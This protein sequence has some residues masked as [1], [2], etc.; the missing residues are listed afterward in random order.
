MFQVL[1]LASS[2]VVSVRT[3]IF[4]LAMK[5]FVLVI[6]QVDPHIPVKLFMSRMHPMLTARV[7]MR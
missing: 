3:I 2:L 7:V 5:Y 4:V 6:L 1:K